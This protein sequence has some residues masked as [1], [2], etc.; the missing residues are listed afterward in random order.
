MHRAPAGLGF[1]VASLGLG[2]MAQAQSVARLDLRPAQPTAPAGATPGQHRNGAAAAW[3]ADDPADSVYRAAR[4]ALS[5]GRYH[6]AA[7]LFGQIEDRYPRS[8]YA[9]DALYWQAFAL[10]RIGGADELETARDALRRQASRYATASTRGDARALGTRINAALARRGDADAAELVTEMGAAAAEP[11]RAPQAPAAAPRPPHPPHAP[12]A[13]RPPRVGTARADHDDC[14]E[15]EDDVKAAALSAV[16]QMDSDRALPLLRK[17]LARRDAGS[18]CLRRKAVFLVSQTQSP[19]T[20]NI[21]LDAARN[22]SD[23][24]VRQQ[25]V[26]WLSQAG[27][28]HAV[29]ALDSIVRTSKD[30]ELQD[31]AIFALSQQGGT[32]ALQALRAYAERSDIDPDARAKAIFWIGQQGGAD[33]GTFLRGIYSTLTSDDLKERVLFSVAQSGDK[34]NTRWLLDVAKDS[35]EPTDLRGKALFWAGQSGVSLADLAGLYSTLGDRAMKEQLIFVLSQRNGPAAVDRLMEVARTEK[36]P[37]LR[38]KAIF[39]LGQSSDPRAAALLTQ[40]LDGK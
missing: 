25:A 37:E 10:Y 22:D 35:R 13:P 29:A 21:L 3:L 32:R 28:E 15:D 7:E 1:V 27:G 16:L 14:G 18:I 20:E 8:R 30:P 11:P 23:S 2:V 38:K 36:D 4:A 24:E 6:E 39:W 31:K 17:V 19:E 26:F 40:I 33:A 12:P 5:R 34:A 9:P